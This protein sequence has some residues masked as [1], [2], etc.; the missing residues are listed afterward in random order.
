M[1]AELGIHPASTESV[2]TE[3]LAGRTRDAELQGWRGS[4]HR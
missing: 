2:M 3:V 1:A 4:V